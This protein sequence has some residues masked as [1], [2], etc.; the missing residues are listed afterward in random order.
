MYDLAGSAAIKRTFKLDETVA[1]AG[2]VI[3]NA[4]TTG[5]A[6]DATTTS[7]ADALGLSLDTGTYSTTQGD[8]EGMITVVIN[9]L[10]VHK[11]LASG[12]ATESTAL[13]TLQNTSAD[14]TGLTITDADV[15]TADIDGGTTWGI[16][17][18]NVG[19]S[20]TI[21]TFSSAV[22]I[23]VTVP[24]PRTIAVDDQF[25]FVPWNPTGTGAAGNDGNTAV[26]FSTLFTQADGA[27]ASGTGANAQVVELGLNGT[28][29]S[30]VAFL[31]IDSVYLQDTA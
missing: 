24:F 18:N 31:L 16:R 21:T 28:L 29:D 9:P 11:F 6:E 27:I 30:W 8:A 17:G 2:V 13:T 1:N 20:R 26:Q 5:N 7:A 23:A 4:A 10:G 15:G 3:K 12:G 22:S 14:A 25:L 19:L